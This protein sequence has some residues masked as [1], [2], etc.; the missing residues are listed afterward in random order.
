MVR[1][2]VDGA[3]ARRLHQLLLTSSWHSPRRSLAHA[4]GR[5][6]AYHRRMATCPRHLEP[7]ASR[8]RRDS[9]PARRLDSH[10]I[11]D[12][13]P[14]RRRRRGGQTAQR[15]GANRTHQDV[16]HGRFPESAIPKTSSLSLGFSR[17]SRR[18]HRRGRHATARRTSMQGA[19][20]PKRSTWAPWMRRR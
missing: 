12:A 8:H 19:A 17:T 20:G 5:E 6:A 1:Q 16:P 9:G 4:F 13:R 10:R 2:D 15:R 3:A 11:V 18:R 7:R 14:D